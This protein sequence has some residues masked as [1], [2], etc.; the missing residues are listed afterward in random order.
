M[1]DPQLEN[2]IVLITGANHGIGAVTAR[3]FAAQ[4]ALVAIHFLRDAPVE[5]ESYVPLHVVKIK[6]AR[7]FGD[8]SST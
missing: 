6:N 3:T 8:E 4:G 1:I 2:K 5:D 7:A